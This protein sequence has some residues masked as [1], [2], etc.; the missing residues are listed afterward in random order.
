MKNR[1]SNF[2]FSYTGIPRLTRFLWQSKNRVRRN[3]RYA[4]QSIE[5]KKCKK[6]LHNAEI[7]YYKIVL[8]ILKHFSGTFRRAQTLKLGEV[9]IERADLFIEILSR[10]FY[11]PPYER[12]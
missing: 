3:S 9:H 4:S 12:T 6:N 7:L 2:G 11:R 5:K 1:K 10:T 8:C